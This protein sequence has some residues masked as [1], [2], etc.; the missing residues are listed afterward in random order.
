MK[1]HSHPTRWAANPVGAEASTR[2]NPMM[3]VSSAYCV[4]VNFLL[5]RLA[6][7]AAKALVPMP[8]VTLSKAI[9]PE[10]AGRL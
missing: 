8:P 5:V 3:L 1:N 6:M 4:A 10:S 9:T 2:G 7:K